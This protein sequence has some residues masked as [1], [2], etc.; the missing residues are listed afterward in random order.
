MDELAQEYIEKKDTFS[1]D[2]DVKNV[3]EIINE[4]Y[5]MEEIKLENIPTLVVDIMKIVEGYNTLSGIEK[6]RLVI[7]TIKKIIDISNVTGTLEPIV[8]M[9]VDSM[10]DKIIDVDRGNIVI[11]GKYKDNLKRLFW[12]CRNTCERTCCC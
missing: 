9:M 7:D 11:N 1:S 5:D 3:S 4:M 8:L 2:P 12:K 10:I 6:K